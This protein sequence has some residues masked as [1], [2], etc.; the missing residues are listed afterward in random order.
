MPTTPQLTFVQRTFDLAAYAG[1][2]VQLRWLYRSDAV[3]TTNSVGEGWYVD[4]ITISHAQVPGSCV[5]AGD[6]VF[7]DGFE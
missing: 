1:Q 6:A 2:S 3:A 7:S 5:A 4:D